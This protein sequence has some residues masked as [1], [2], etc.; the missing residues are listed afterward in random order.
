MA[1]FVNTTINS[2]VSGTGG[3]DTIRNSA[4]GATIRAGAGNDYI[5]S[6]TSSSHMINNGYGYVTIDGGAGDD[7]IESFDPHV[8]INGGDG[9]DIIYPIGDY[10]GVTVRGGAGNDTLVNSTVESDNGKLYQYGDGDGND[11]IISFSESDTLALLDN[12]TYSTMRSG[13]DVF[14]QI[15]LNMIDLDKAFGKNIHIIGGTRS[16]I[17]ASPQ[18]KL[19]D[20][21][22]HINR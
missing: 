6:S 16:Q 18:L 22:Y 7:T 12:P 15:G 3:D 5:Y 20:S 21:N 8:S 19:G 9:D 11:V 4:G 14:V 10:V 13:N 1:S 2:I 17:D